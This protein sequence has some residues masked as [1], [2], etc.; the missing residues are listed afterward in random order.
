MSMY[1]IASFTVG[2]GGGTPSFTNIPQNYKHLQIRASFRGTRSGATAGDI[3]YIRFNGD[4][5]VTYNA[6]RFHGDGS[7]VSFASQNT[8]GFLYFADSS[9]PDAGSPANVFGTQIW[10]I[11]DY[12]DP[13]KNKVVKLLY[14]W[15]SGTN[16]FA[17][18]SVGN[19]RSTAPIT[20]ISNM[21][22]ANSLAAQFT[23]VDLY[24]VT[25]S[26]MRGA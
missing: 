13:N 9:L 17:G 23:R 2:A 26:S 21:G 8:F 14:G 16:G 15:E 25:D 22:V 7:T 4:F 19:W 11:L 10:D 18:V 6:H 12:S 5:G 1:P 24:G 20:T 3:T